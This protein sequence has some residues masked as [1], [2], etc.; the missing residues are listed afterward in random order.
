MKKKIQSFMRTRTFR[1]LAPSMFMMSLMV[2]GAFAAEGDFDLAT[3]MTTTVTKIVADLLA[4]IAGVLPVTVTLIA[5]SIGITYAIKF[6]KKLIG[7]AG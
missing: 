1:I 3:T 7:K 4:M 6:I 5:A 2:C